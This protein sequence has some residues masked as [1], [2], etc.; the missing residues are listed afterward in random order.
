[1]TALNPQLRERL[2]E[3]RL[4]LTYIQN[5]L[6]RTDREAVVGHLLAVD[7]NDDVWPWLTKGRLEHLRWGVDAHSNS[8]NGR[9]L[10]QEDLDGARA[11][12]AR[13]R[14]IRLALAA[15]I[16]AE[17]GQGAVLNATWDDVKLEG[18]LWSVPKADHVPA[19]W[20]RKHRRGGRAPAAEVVPL[21]KGAPLHRVFNEAREVGFGV[22][23]LLRLVPEVKHSLA[24]LG[25]D[26][27]APPDSNAPVPS[28]VFAKPAGDPGDARYPVGRE[29]PLRPD[30]LRDFLRK[31]YASYVSS[32]SPGS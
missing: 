14:R 25:G 2:Q 10:R 28:R 29:E 32:V 3:G 15:S 24:T 8:Y 1:M 13:K 7:I 4:T 26:L 16:L 31:T 11:K 23:L 6:G 18:E 27:Y 20:S 17:V 21:P 22:N 9:R 5:V 30:A 12:V 19:G